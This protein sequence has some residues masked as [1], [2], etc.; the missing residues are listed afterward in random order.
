LT[1]AHFLLNIHKKG[2]FLGAAVLGRV[3]LDQSFDPLTEVE[4]LSTCPRW[5]DVVADP[6]WKSEKYGPMHWLWNLKFNESCANFWSFLQVFC[7]RIWSWLRSLPPGRENTKKY[8]WMSEQFDQKSLG[9]DG[10]TKNNWETKL[11]L[12]MDF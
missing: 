6:I 11:D 12:L 5:W 4:Y 10:L 3:W 2:L 9:N 7:W 8:R 1:H